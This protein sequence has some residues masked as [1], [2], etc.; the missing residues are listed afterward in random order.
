MDDIALMKIA[1]DYATDG[2]L[3][4]S[5]NSMRIV[6]ASKSA[7]ETLGYS[8]AELCEL[9]LCDI[10]KKLSKEDVK[11][12]L[13]CNAED[14]KLDKVIEVLIKKKDGEVFLA[15]ISIRVANDE[16]ATAVIHNI[17]ERKKIEIELESYKDHLEMMIRVQTEDLVTARDTAL[18]AEKAMSSFLA[19]MSHELRTPLHGVLSF[20]SIALKK[21]DVLPQEK[22]K[23]F[24]S[25]I[26]ESAE[27][28]LKILNDLLD[29][30]KLKSG[31]MAYSYGEKNIVDILGRVI[32][33]M[34]IICGYKNICTNIH[35]TGNEKKISIDAN[36]ILQ[37]FRNIYSNAIKFSGENG[38]VDFYI[39]YSG[40]AGVG[41][42]I[43]DEGEGVPEDDL[44]RIFDPFIQSDANSKT[45]GGTGL[46][47]PICK[48]IIEVGHGGRLEMNN[49]EGG[50]ACVCVFIPTERLNKH[51]HVE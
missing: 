1:L 29:L 18:S 9:G 32:R 12:Y 11:N 15:E 34:E 10:Q 37:V 39:D 22:I 26:H 14:N 19:N 6:S 13:S 24:L 45:P 41:I 5:R 27:T 49:R 36:R 38:N 17:E 16:Y 35:I 4:L 47:L 28:L 40:R 30:S 43:C 50:G 7:Y 46:G 20:S 51:A 3:L 31:K 21:I 42:E 2:V 48:E 8:E 33:E 44:V 23:S 25:E